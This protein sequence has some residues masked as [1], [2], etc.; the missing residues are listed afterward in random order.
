MT[1]VLTRST[2]NIPPLKDE[3][4]ELKYFSPKDKARRLGSYLATTM[5]PHAEPSEPTFIEET[6]K[7]VE[8]FLKK[9]C[10]S[11]I[12]F[13]NNS[14][15]T[16]KVPKITKPQELMVYPISCSKISPTLY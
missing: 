3:N 10:E 14:N 13:M 15:T 4:S 6:N 1:K 2:R 8:D 16:L 12:D 7:F 5:P 9:P 11:E